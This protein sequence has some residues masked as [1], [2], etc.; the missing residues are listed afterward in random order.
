MEPHIWDRIQ[1]VYYLALPLSATE[2]IDFVARECGFDPLLIREICSLLQADESDSQFLEAPVF[3]L[4]LRVINSDTRTPS[5]EVAD[6]ADELVGS[7]IDGRYVV[8]SC[9]AVGGMARVYV[10]RDLRLHQ[11]RV[12]VKVLLDESLRNEWVVQ[13]FQQER[14]ALARVDHPG[15][16][17][18]LDAGELPDKKPYLVMQ[19]VEG[20]SLRE[21]IAAKPEGIEFP[22]AASIIRGIGAALSAVHEKKIYHR[23][24]KPENIMLQRLG[25]AEEHVKILDFGIARV[26]ESLI[27]PSTP[28]GASTMGTVAY[29]SPEQLRGDRVAAA[30]DLYSF[31]IIAFEMLTGRRPFL[32]DTPAHLAEMQRQ[33]VRAKPADLRPRLPEEADAIILNGLAFDAKARSLSVSEFGDRLSRA[34]LAGGEGGSEQ[35]AGSGRSLEAAATPGLATALDSFDSSRASIS[36]AQTQETSLISDGKS[37]PRRW[38][39]YAVAAALIIGAMTGAYWLI[40]RNNGLFGEPANSRSGSSSPHR[41]LTYS[42]TVQEM[43][44]GLPYQDPFESSGQEIFE[45]G[46]KFRLNVSSR[47]A[48]YLY[49]FNEGP[50]EKDQTSFTIIYP[51]PATNEGSR[52]EQNQKMQT[53]WNT[54]S[55]E[56]G[57][58][59]FWII[60]SAT[61]VT[62]I[63][64][65]RHD[66]FKN[67]EGAITDAE[68]ARSLRAFLAEHSVPEPETTKDTAKQ[69]TSLRAS[70]D[71]LVKLLELEH[72]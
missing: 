48:G 39:V 50:P 30:G 15:V 23:D 13:K 45:N 21:M 16:V 72:Q 67:K 20:M 31:A 61:E 71:L 51:T 44:N 47:Q 27:G 68:I 38:L 9:L 69:R 66:A 53:N 26:K 57:T 4:G 17:N 37:R 28:K 62:P 54:F 40:S 6:P 35:D 7:T 12:V 46:Y 10:A 2:R 1:E 63:E 42:L 33:G 59:R 14:E 60:W 56:K 8:V 49:V 58:E 43:R 64:I 11:R 5:P 22:R 70:G 19:Y 55:G 29:M 65:A 52:L 41:T 24:L 34:L 32:A 3:E 25:P 18:I 36:T